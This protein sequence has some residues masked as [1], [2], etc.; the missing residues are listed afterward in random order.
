MD[1]KLFASEPMITNPS[2]IDVDAKGRVWVA[3]IQWYRGKAK[4]PPA[5]KIQ[6]LE[7]TDGDGAA[8]K[9]TV[10]VDG[11]FAPMSV[12]V[13]GD[14]VYAFVK[15]ELL[16][17]E[18][19]NGDLKAD[20]PAKVILKGFSNANH[21]HTAH[22][23]VVGP[24]HKWYMAHGDTGFDVTGNDGS[25]IKFKWGAMVRGELD[26]TKLENVAVNFR[27]PYEICVN[28]FGEMY[29]SDNDDDGNESV[30]VCWILEGGDYGWFGTP[31][32]KKNLLNE[33][34]PVGT[35]FRE[36]WHFRG[37]IPGYVP[38]TVQTGFGS[39]CGMCYYESD[40][41]GAKLQNAPLH[42]DPGPARGSRVSS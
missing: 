33:C 16:M 17:W 27:N 14:R 8:D 26:G 21:D 12:C 18:D 25:K 37:F 4:T 22:S 28:S 31:P 34:V 32:F 23:I 35:P 42:C 6:V 2:C 36:A 40:L 13:V 39:P 3:E 20:G 24:D 19:K 11:L 10:F 41:F 5:D 9:A 30:R 38:A 29:C 7:D 15:G 1:V